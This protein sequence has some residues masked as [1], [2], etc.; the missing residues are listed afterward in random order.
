M[1]LI[2]IAN[3]MS[4]HALNAYCNLSVKAAYR[5]ARW[6]LLGGSSSSSSFISGRASYHTSTGPVSKRWY[7]SIVCASGYSHSL[8][9]VTGTFVTMQLSAFLNLRPKK[10]S[11]LND[12]FMLPLLT[13]GIMLASAERTSVNSISS[14]ELGSGG[15][16]CL[17]AALYLPPIKRSLSKF[18][19]S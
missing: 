3:D 4:C 19:F 14:S 2:P 13:L 10:G 12:G 18:V 16:V 15:A 11:T 8:L 9:P 5:A 7:T 6:C 17:Y 1:Q